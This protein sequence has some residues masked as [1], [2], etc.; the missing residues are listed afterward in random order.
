MIALGHTPTHRP[1][2]LQSASLTRALG[3]PARVTYGLHL[4][5][6][7]LPTHCKC[8][9]YLHPYGWVSYDVSE[10]Q[11]MIKAAVAVS[12]VVSDGKNK[13]TGSTQVQVV[14]LAGVWSGR[15]TSCGGCDYLATFTLAQNGA[16]VTGTSRD[17]WSGSE[18]NGSGAVA[19]GVSAPARSPPCR[20]SRN[21]HAASTRR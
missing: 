13:T 8:E 14:N 10:T 18:T 6:K 5:P 20:P 12:V 3:M 9:V 15:L 11:R 17:R 4:F 16:A 1:H 19:G 7:N 21:C 2:P